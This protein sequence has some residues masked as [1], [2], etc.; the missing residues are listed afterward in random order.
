MAPASDPAT[1]AHATRCVDMLAVVKPPAAAI[2]AGVFDIAPISAGV[3]SPPC[4]PEESVR[5]VC[6]VRM[7]AVAPPAAAMPAGVAS[8]LPS[9]YDCNDL[10]PI[11]KPAGPIV[12]LKLI[13]RGKGVSLRCQPKTSS[14]EV[15]PTFPANTTVPSDF[16]PSAELRLHAMATMFAHVPICENDESSSLPTLTTVPSAFRPS[17]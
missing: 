1:S 15:S 12:G 4:A 3:G 2:A 11:K 5:F 6:A 13:D 16:R 7:E 17:D 8:H 14:N 10:P 9:K